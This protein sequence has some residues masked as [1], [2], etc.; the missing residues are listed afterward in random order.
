MDISEAKSASTGSRNGA[1]VSVSAIV[2]CYNEED[3]I[4]ELY[5]RLSAACREAAEDNYEIILVNDGSKDRTWSLIEQM[6][7]TDSHIIGVNLSRNHGH[8]LALTAGLSIANGQRI[9]II[10]AD[11]QDPPELLV[12]MMT[13]LDA[14]VDV[15][16]GQRRKR[17]GETVFKRVMASIFY[18]FLDY[19]TEFP[20]PRDTGDFRLIS[21]RAL[22][23][24]LA[25]PEQFRFVRG[26]VSWIGYRQE[27]YIYDRAGRFA[28]TT[29][30]PFTKMLRLA[31]DAIT[32]FSIRPLRLASHLG[33][34]LAMLSIP[35]I[36]YILIG[37]FSGKTVEGWTSLMAVVVILGSVQMLV[38]G[39]IGEYLGRTYMQTKDRPL[40]IVQDVVGRLTEPQVMRIN[41]LGFFQAVAQIDD[42]IKGEAPQ[43]TKNPVENHRDPRIP[44]H[45]RESLLERS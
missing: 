29:N 34:L 45:G 23:A 3:C 38:L 24:L 30:Y 43:E 6:S 27:A 33:I 1:T 12:P 26:M 37:W 44:G 40:F 25:M 11:L 19:L 36:A 14:G 17:E 9:F 28:G 7:Q 32:G 39:L 10:D 2:P 8:Q 5:G 21:R 16:F 18:R 31:I 15:V 4:A 41:E 22:N 42:S 35:L 13:R 20:I